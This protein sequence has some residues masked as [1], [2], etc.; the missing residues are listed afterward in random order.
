M[1]VATT[2]FE[3][4]KASLISLFKG[5]YP[6]F[7]VFCEEIP[8]TQN[9][10]PEPS[11]EDYVF[12]EI[13][14]TGN[15][16]IDAEHTG[17][18]VLVIASLHTKAESNGEYLKMGQDIDEA[19]R[20]VFRF[21]DGG[22]ARAITVPDVSLKVVDKVLHCTFTLAF[23]DSTQEPPPFPVMEELNTIIKPNERT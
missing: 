10:A 18:R 9:D 15:E 17:R 14:P 11:L 6:A 23:T 1:R 7:D 5:L 19:I 22:E 16:T 13:I 2:I 8:K 12:L 3:S 4:I 20:P 21:E